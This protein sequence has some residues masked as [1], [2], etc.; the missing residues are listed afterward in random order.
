MNHKRFQALATT[1]L[2]VMKVLHQLV[3]LISKFSK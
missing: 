2:T 3:D 1:L